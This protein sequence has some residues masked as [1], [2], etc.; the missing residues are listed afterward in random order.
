[1]FSADAHALH[2][3][4]QPF[5]PQLSTPTHNHPSLP[6]KS[7]KGSLNSDDKFLLETLDIATHTAGARVNLLKSGWAASGRCW[8]VK[9]PI[10]TTRCDRRSAITVSSAY[11]RSPKP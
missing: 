5:N 4:L 8:V 3:I 10:A 11:E 9:K 7:R 2:Q 6:R 1:M